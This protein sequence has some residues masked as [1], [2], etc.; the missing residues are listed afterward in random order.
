[1]K[2]RSFPAIRLRRRSVLSRLLAAALC[3][4]AGAPT[5]AA[6]PRQAAPSPSAI[7]SLAELFRPPEG[8]PHRISSASADPASNLD[9]L[10]LAAGAE[11]PLALVKGPGVLRHLWITVESDDPYYARLLVLRARWDGESAPSIE[12]P[13]G[14]FFG[15]GH[16]L[17]ADVD[18][19]PVR[20]AGDGRARSSFWPMPFNESADVTL[21]N[22]SGRPALVFWTIDWTELAAKGAGLRTLHAHFRASAR[23]RQL[24]QHKVAEIQGKGHYVGTVLSI[25]SGEEGWP[26]EGDDRFFIDGATT[27]ALVGTGVEGYFDDAW[28][29]RVG[30]GPFGGVTVWEGTGAGARSTMCRWH[31]VD[32]IAFEKGLAVT[33][34]RVGYAIRNKVEQLVNDRN[35]AFSS[36]AFWYQEEPHGLLTVLPPQ[37]ERLPFFEVRVEP[38]EKEILGSLVVP[39][40]APAPTRVD[41]PFLAYG[42]EVAFAPRRIEDGLLALPFDVPGPREYDLYLRL[43]RGPDRGVWQAWLDGE[44][45]GAP[46]DLHA[47]RALLRE[48]LLGRRHLTPTGHTLELRCTGKNLE[49]TGFSLGID[50][51]MARWYP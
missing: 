1:M 17:E 26:G 50:S 2:P 43:T 32:P 12:V 19:L 18:S 38:E 25:W 49:S 16:G 27:P 6:A 11:I 47:P 9:F 10:K 30:T 21:R 23:D 51:F 15:V 35:D 41:G 4:F 28:G 22:D 36:V 34:E 7:P 44:P 31:V 13:I 3:G 46:I 37:N 33:F 24:R 8:K 14:D 40:G 20:V 5:L 48:Q 45:I 39:E 29:L 42:A